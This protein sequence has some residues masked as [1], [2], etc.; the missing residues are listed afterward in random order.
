FT[1]I[2]AKGVVAT[3]PSVTSIP[4]FT[5]IPYAPLPAETIAAILKTELLVGLYQFLAVA[6]SGRISPL[7]LEAGE[8]NALLIEDESLPSLSAQIS[9]YAAGSGNPLLQAYA[10]QIGQLYG[11][12]RH[13]TTNDLV[14]LTT[15]G[16]RKSV[17]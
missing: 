8:V 14:L 4:Y 9:A 5:T 15:S 7:K 11:K 10:T 1:S 16:D 13:A 2:G 3:I 17:V 6:T 12:A